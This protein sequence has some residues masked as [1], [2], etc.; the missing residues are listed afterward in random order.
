MLNYL[1]TNSLYQEYKMK[2]RSLL[3]LR[4][5]FFETIFNVFQERYKE[6]K[7]DSSMLEREKYMAMVGLTQTYYNDLKTKSV[8]DVNLETLHTLNKIVYF[9][10]KLHQD[11]ERAQLITSISGMQTPLSGVQDDVTYIKPIV[12]L[13]KN[14]CWDTK[15]QAPNGMAANNNTRISTCANPQSATN[16]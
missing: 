15:V 8:A 4:T 11:N 5:L 16:T 13:I 12:A 6:N 1:N 3:A 7:A 10:Y 9:L 14:G 2:V